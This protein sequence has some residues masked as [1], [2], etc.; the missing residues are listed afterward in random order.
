MECQK[1][2]PRGD[3]RSICMFIKKQNKENTSSLSAWGPYWDLFWGHFFKASALNR[4][5]EKRFVCPEAVFSS[6]KDAQS[7]EIFHWAV[8]QLSKW[9]MKTLPNGVSVEGLGSTAFFRSFY[10]FCAHCSQI[11]LF[12]CQVVSKYLLYAFCILV[13]H[14]YLPPVAFLVPVFPITGDCWPS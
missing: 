3:L 11:R 8:G 2:V 5:F 9:K 14:W 6:Q 13:P 4:R 7:G 1:A 12:G 10:K